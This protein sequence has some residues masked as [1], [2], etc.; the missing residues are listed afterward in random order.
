MVMHHAQHQLASIHSLQFKRRQ[1]G[2]SRCAI[3]RCLVRFLSRLQ[4]QTCKA[5][6]YFVSHKPKYKAPRLNTIRRRQSETRKWRK[7]RRKLKSE[8]EV[9]VDCRC[10]Q[11]M[12]RW[13]CCDVTTFRCLPSFM[14]CTELV[15]SASRNVSESRSAVGEQSS[16][17]LSRLPN[18]GA[19]KYL[20]EKAAFLRHLLS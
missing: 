10:N 4:M 1:L 17:N 3:L 6:I 11:G 7:V 8:K 16:H 5:S 19:Y 14:L 2:K 15:K 12:D 20:D 13:S 18:T 9:G